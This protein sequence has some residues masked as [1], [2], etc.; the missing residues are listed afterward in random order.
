MPEPTPTPPETKVCD[1]CDAV[2]GKSEKTCPK[3]SVDFEELEDTVASVSKAQAI[4]EKRKKATEPKPCAKC[5]K[6][7]EGACAIPAKK[8]SGLRGLGAILRKGK[9]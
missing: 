9:A 4:I 6:V 5:S 2:I 8:Q 3:C 1:A 7:H